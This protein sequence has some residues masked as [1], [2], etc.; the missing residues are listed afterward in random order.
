LAAL[1]VSTTAIILGT[2]V[3]HGRSSAAG[4]TSP[5]SQAAQTSQTAPTTPSSSPSPSAAPS[6]LTVNIRPYTWEDRCLQWYL[7]NRPP[8]EVPPPPA[9][10]DARGWATALKAVPGGNMKIELSVQG[11]SGQVVVL[12]AL[13]VRTVS[14]AAP[15]PWSAFSMGQ[16]CG[17]GITPS[18]FDVDLDASRPL[19]KP[20]PGTQ[21]DTVVP[22]ID[23]PFRVSATDPQVLDVEA[24]TAAANVSWYLELEWSSGDRQGALRIDNH[25]R[26][27]QTSALKG[28]PMFD[29]NADQNIW[30]PD[31]TSNGG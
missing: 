26:P 25:G 23:F 7:L 19:T 10:E 14:K 27:F 29:Y 30:S 17:S 6:P 1:T 8:T 13:H 21:G 5:T 18:S 3:G 2:M 28:R 31:L 12:N 20:T 9:E 15:L 24:H 4:P 11:T 22:A 16:G